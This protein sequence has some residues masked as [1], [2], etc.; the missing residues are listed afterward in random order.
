M[1]GPFAEV[2]LPTERRPSELEVKAVYL[3]HFA[4]FV[5]WPE[6][7]QSRGGSFSICV[8]G[9]DPFGPILERTLAGETLDG[10]PAE[11]KRIE[12]PR[13]AEGCRILFISASERNRLSRVLEAT[14]DHAVLTVSDVENFAGAGGM[15]GL[16][17]EESRVRFDVNLDAARAADLTLSSELLKVA[18]RV[19]GN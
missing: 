10:R 4:K 13:E 14:R 11:T 7:A 2:G 6:R 16:V 19:W 15:I 12:D 8:L 9:V 3:Y 17:L 1:L 18:R 5:R